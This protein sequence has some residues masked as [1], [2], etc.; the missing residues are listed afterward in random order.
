MNKRIVQDE[1]DGCSPPSPFLVPEYHLPDVA[2]V[3]DLRVSEAEFPENDG[4]VDSIR[5]REA[6]PPG[7]R[8]G[9]GSRVEDEGGDDDGQDEPGWVVNH[10]APFRSSTKHTYPGTSPSTL[11]DHG[12]LMMA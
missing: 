9:R 3:A 6:P 12:K 4:P 11:Y 1:H 8:G 7:D 10:R 2:D 5:A